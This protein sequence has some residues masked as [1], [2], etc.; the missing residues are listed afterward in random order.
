MTCNGKGMGL[1]R[2]EEEDLAG[3]DF[4]KKN[5]GKYGRFT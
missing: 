1:Y 2:G 3:V 4:L 5:Y